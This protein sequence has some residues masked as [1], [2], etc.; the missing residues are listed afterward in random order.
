MQAAFAKM[1]VNKE[2]KFVS[3]TD[4]ESVPIPCATLCIVACLVRW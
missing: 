1:D 4:L 3:W 2:S